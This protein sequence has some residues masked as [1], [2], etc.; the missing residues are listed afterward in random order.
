M[1]SRNVAG[2]LFAALF[3]SAANAEVRVWEGTLTLPTYEEGAP[4]PNPPF[5]LFATNRFNYPYTLR[6]SLTGRRTDHTWR[7]I[8]LENEYL[9]CSVLPD[10][11]GHLYTCVDKL[12][13]KPMFYAN[14]SIKKANIGYRGA[15]AAFGVEFNFPVS[16]NWVSMSPVS[17]SYSNHDDGSASVT[18]GNIDRVYGMEWMVE[19]ILRPGS[20]VL[21]ERVTLSNRSDARHRFY[22]WNNGAV[23]IWDDSHIEYPMR[24]A[25]SHG[26]TEVQPWPVDAEGADLSIIRNQTKGPVSL[27]VHGSREPFMGIWNPQT[28][29]G[30]VHFADYAEL[31]AKKIWSW[32]VDADGLDWRRALSDNNSAYAE[33]QAGLFRNQET[34]AFLEP[35]QTIQFSEFWMPVRGT[36]GISRANLSGVVY[37][38]R[39]G[40]A[41]R[42]AL[43]VNER[44]RGASIHL[45]DGNRSVFEEQPDLSPEHTWTR[46]V[47]AETGHPLTF[48]LKDAAGTLLLRQKEGEYD[49]TPADQIRVG[50]QSTHEFP[51]DVRKTEDD[52][53]QVGTDQELNGEL[54]DA[55]EAY[56]HGLAKYPESLA[57]RKAAGR[58]AASLSRS[59]EAIRYL[60]PVHDANTSDPET[61]Y[62]LGVAYDELGDTRKAQEAFEA[63]HRMPQFRAAGAL[64]LGELA[65]QDGRVHEAEH[66]LAESLRS[67]ASLRAAEE[68]IAIRRATGDEQGAK[69]LATDW[70]REHPLSYF[71]QEV[72]QSPDLASLGA[73]PYRVLNVA[74]EY[75]RVGL[76]RDALKVLSRSYPASPPDH[77]EPGSVLPQNHPLVVYY[78][79]YCKQRLGMAAGN[80]Y[81]AASKLST[82]Y[83][84]PNSPETLRVLKAAMEARPSDGTAHY[85]AGT[86]FFSRGLTDSALREW[87]QARHLAPMTPVLHADIGEALLRVRHDYSGALS[88]FQDG[89]AADATNPKLYAGMEQALSLLQQP[90]SQRVQALE[91]YPNPA[92][93]PSELVYELALNL[94]EAGDSIR[95]RHLFENRFFP[96][97]EGGTNV[98]QVWIE[99]LLEQALQLQAANNCP[100]ALRIINALGAEVPGLAFTRD[101]MGPF[102]ESARAQYLIGSEL[103]AC[104]RNEDAKQH[105][106]RAAA[107]TGTDGI[108]WAYAAAVKLG[109]ASQAEWNRKLETA[110]AHAEMMSVDSSVAAYRLGCIELALGHRE[111]AEER[112]TQALLL[113]DRL[114]AHHLTRRSRAWA[115][116]GVRIGALN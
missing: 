38:S 111:A 40:N 53:V 63:A 18:V 22:W 92:Q 116:S 76:Y 71:L 78:R 108:S 34:Y 23:E 26:F 109:T 20:T 59:E 107:Q 56:E 16:H 32:G 75:M 5:D 97:E 48:E 25:A 114:M 87:D 99:V 12:S 70:L 45:L 88:A 1:R 52:W 115:A 15:W 9:K 91:R 7:A 104:G 106:E 94:A 6:E 2:V 95:A 81:A 27:F 47:A 10:I 13:G 66:Y 21:E 8:Y 3:V 54:L 74:S 50:P 113:P 77:S 102:I 110:L 96:R 82:V 84:F 103:S 93:M 36:G 112:F 98:R 4:D 68:L 37:L 69:S 60:E 29:T 57:L 105:F 64:R 67:E 49:W 55:P 89:L 51:P 35:L 17:F 43:N 79:G 44:L 58:L 14:P 46:E 73:H 39:V 85:L 86:F 90:A 42:V 72:L 101:G 41:V 24:F 31:P 61:S 100:A 83:V 11:G 65:A 80:D 19:M 28:N 30:T 62:Y 33:V